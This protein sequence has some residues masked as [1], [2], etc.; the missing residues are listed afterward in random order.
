[1]TSG[2][3]KKPAT[4]SNTSAPIRAQAAQKR[5]ERAGV[6]PGFADE[7]NCFSIEEAVLDE[8]QLTEGY[9]TEP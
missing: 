5:I 1:M 2:P 8:D 6:F 3:T 7:P 4:T 9:V